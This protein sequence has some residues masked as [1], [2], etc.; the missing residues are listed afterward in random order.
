MGLYDSRVLY[1]RLLLLLI[2]L[3]INHLLKW[4]SVFVGGD[5]TT[6]AQQDSQAILPDADSI[7]PIGLA[8]CFP[9]GRRSCVLWGRASV[10][11]SGDLQ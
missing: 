6:N 3:S 11:E 5:D 1:L 2:H 4:T 8:S 9:D 7:F 10:A